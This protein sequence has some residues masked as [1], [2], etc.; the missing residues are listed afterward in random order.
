MTDKKKVLVTGVS[1]QIGTIIRLR[2]GDRYALSGIDLVGVDDVPCVVADLADLAAIQP[3]FENMDTVVHLGADPNPRASWES[4]LK[5]NIVAT[6]N[7]F[8][9]ARLAG[10]RRIIFASSNHAVGFYPLKQ[11]PYKAVYDGRIGEVDWPIAPL[12]TDL[13]RPDSDYGVSKAFGEALGS[14]FHDQFGIS[15]IC[16][17]IGWVMTP[18]DPSFSP[19]ALSLWLSHRDVAQLIQKSVDASPSV[20]F[21]VVN[22][23]SAN[24]LSI[25]DI[26]S[27]RQILGYEPEDGAGDTWTTKPDSPSII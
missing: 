17:R 11:E 2:L 20:G 3:A 1:G 6:R 21:T 10:V 22:G 7:V 12:T 4:I 14:Y 24:V 19:A 13:L 18:D 16:L 8:E 9:A 26:E 15:V 27:T 25:W 23:E 5:N